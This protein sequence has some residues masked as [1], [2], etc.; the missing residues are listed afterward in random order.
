MK[1]TSQSG[2]RD[3]GWLPWTMLGAGVLMCGLATLLTNHPL[4]LGFLRKG[5]LTSVSASRAPQRVGLVLRGAGFARRC[6][7]S[8]AAVG[9]ANAFARGLASCGH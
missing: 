2:V 6:R 8:A 9:T 3:A 7:G 1:S 5:I 4:R